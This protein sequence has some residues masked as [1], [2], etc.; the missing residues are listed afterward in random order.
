MTDFTFNSMKSDKSGEPSVVFDSTPD[1]IQVYPIEKP[2]T[3]DG[4]AADLTEWESSEAYARSDGSSASPSFTCK[5]STIWVYHATQGNAG[6]TCTRLEGPG[7]V[8]TFAQGNR[9]YTVTPGT[10]RHA[11]IGRIINNGW[12]ASGIRYK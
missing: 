10:Y 4:A 11:V 12:I 3:E 9:S 8:Y 7:G 5:E 6:I 1:G 2:S